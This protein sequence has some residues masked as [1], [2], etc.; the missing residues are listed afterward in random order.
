M[1]EPLYHLR[2]GRR[3]RAELPAASSVEQAFSDSST[4]QTG[5]LGVESQHSGTAVTF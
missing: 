3:P 1:A 4:L 2:G 5:R